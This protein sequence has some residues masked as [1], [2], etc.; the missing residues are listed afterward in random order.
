MYYLYYNNLS[1]NF[2]KYNFDS[3]CTPNSNHKYTYRPSEDEICTKRQNKTE[4]VQ[5][6]SIR[7]FKHIWDRTEVAQF[8]VI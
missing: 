4:K 5:L 8:Y 1:I 3:A 2:I 7:L 6:I